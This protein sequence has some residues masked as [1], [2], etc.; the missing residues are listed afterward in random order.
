MKDENES[1]ALLTVPCA[2]AAARN[3]RAELER[4]GI[5]V[6][7]LTDDLIEKERW[8]KQG[9]HTLLCPGIASD[10]SELPPFP[11]QAVYLFEDTLRHTC[12][13]LQF[14]TDRICA[15]VYVI[16]QSSVSAGL[17]KRLGASY[18]LCTHADD[19]G[20]LIPTN[21]EPKEG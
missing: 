19:V 8:A 15:P 11:V 7:V 1:Y 16:A 6:A 18:V 10:E 9:V 3:F 20:F 13:Y 12:S 21:F 5:P 2:S 14:A 17:Y 4:H